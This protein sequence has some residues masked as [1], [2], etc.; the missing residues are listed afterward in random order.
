MTDGA[1]VMS[2]FTALDKGIV[3]GIKNEVIHSRILKNIIK[4]RNLLSHGVQK[5][6]EH[7]VCMNLTL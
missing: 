6:L 7:F 1:V 5:F 3:V 2:A 4:G